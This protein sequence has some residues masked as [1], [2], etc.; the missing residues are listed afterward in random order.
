LNRALLSGLASTLAHQTGL[1]VAAENLANVSTTGY[2]AGSVAYADNFY[3]TL[4]TALASTATTGGTAPVQVGAGVSAAA[5]ALDN[6][7]GSLEGTGQA[8]DA[9]IDGNGLFI[10]RGG[11]AT[12]YTRDGS[13]QLDDSGTLA[14]TTTGLRLQGWQAVNG[15]VDTDA[16][17]GDLT[18]PLRTL[19]PPRATTSVQME[20]NL[21]STTASTDAPTTSTIT[22]Y[23]S[24]GEE[25]TVTLS[26]QKTVNDR[27]W[28]VTANVDATSVS[29]TV[30]FDTNGALAAGTMLNLPV[31]LTNGAA[32][33]SV[34]IDLSILTQF[35]D[36]SAPTPT[37]QD[38]Y[39][40]AALQSISITD[41]GM[42]QGEYSDGRSMILGQVAIAG[43]ANAEGLTRAGSNLF[44]PSAAS[45]IP[46]VGAAGED[47]RGEVVGQTLEASNTDL[48][49]SFLDMLITQRAYQASTRVISTA[50]NML[51]ETIN[52]A[53]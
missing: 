43:F 22:V 53:R 27:E 23:D 16:T 26:C 40:A 37:S 39:G 33:M 52:L 44:T 38:G 14:M 3:Q 25:H 2:K 17:T 46:L 10:V 5:V 36:G 24:L 41:G 42:V 19:R 1:D 21:A 35:S 51:E 11:G 4:R 29:S 32:P 8:L 48:T 30:T 31:V 18:F 34:G 13:F 15:T 49:S 6:T 9:A 20:G 45:G 7:Q 12:Y 50:N 28:T 47:G